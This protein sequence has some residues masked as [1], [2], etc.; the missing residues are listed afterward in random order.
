MNAAPPDLAELAGVI[1]RALRQQCE[2]TETLAGVRVGPDEDGL[3]EIIG[4]FDL[5]EVAR[6]LAAWAV[7]QLALAGAKP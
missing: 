5:H 2:Q 3:V 7:L 1:H 6:S 4:L